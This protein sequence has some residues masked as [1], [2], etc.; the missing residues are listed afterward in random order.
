MTCLNCKSELDGHDYIS[1][2]QALEAGKVLHIKEHEVLDGSGKAV[3][4]CAPVECKGIV[5]SDDR[6]V[7][8]ASLT[9][10][11]LVAKHHNFV[12]FNLVPFLPAS[13][14]TAIILLV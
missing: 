5:G 13:R 1:V 8:L 6:Y 7:V 12:V 10:M 9:P 14:L 11:L 3:T 4:M 2:C